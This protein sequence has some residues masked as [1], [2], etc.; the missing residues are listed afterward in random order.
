MQPPPYAVA[1]RAALRHR[2]VE[3][4]VRLCA[5]V[6]LS[7]VR[8]SAPPCACDQLARRKHRAPPMD[9]HRLQTVSLSQALSQQ[10]AP[11]ARLSTGSPALDAALGGGGL[12]RGQLAELCGPPG[13][14]KTRF[15]SL[16]RLSPV[17]PASH[18]PT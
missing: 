13:A 10:A 3:P 16:P 5:T 15:L 2:L 1:V 6:S 9:S 11:S 8:G 17:T 14:G 7:H 12:L 18:P 4:C